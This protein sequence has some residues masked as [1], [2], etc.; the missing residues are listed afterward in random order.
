M[1]DSWSE[2]NRDAYF[3]APHISTGDN[4]NKTVQ[5]RYIQ[6]AGYVRLK[7]VTLSYSIPE[8]ALDRLGMTS[9]RLFFT[10][11]NLWEYSKIRRPLDP[12]TAGGAIRYPM[13]RIYTLGASVSF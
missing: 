2:T 1:T 13:Q 10:G 9:A 4:K 11:A 6:N 12:E 7:N 3:P 5:S 8:I